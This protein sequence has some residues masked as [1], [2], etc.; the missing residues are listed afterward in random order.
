MCGLS[1]SLKIQINVFILF[2]YFMDLACILG[3]SGQY[4][5]SVNWIL[6]HYFLTFKKDLLYFMC[7]CMC[8]QFLQKPE[9]GDRVP[10]VGV[11]GCCEPSDMGD[12]DQIECAA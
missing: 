1:D 2:Y 7:D 4:I 5:L 10:E 6:S 9:E 11:T 8:V 12:R 3:C